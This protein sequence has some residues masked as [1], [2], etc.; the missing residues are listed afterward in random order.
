MTFQHDEGW[1]N[2]IWGLILNPYELESQERE[3]K[4][5]LFFYLALEWKNKILGELRFPW[6]VRPFAEIMLWL[7]KKKKSFLQSEL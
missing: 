3:R 5:N 7:K 6:K 4:L 2:A 1:W